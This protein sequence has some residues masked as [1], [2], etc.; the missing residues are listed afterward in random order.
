MSKWNFIL[1]IWI[2]YNEIE[3][4]SSSQENWKSFVPK[5]VKENLETAIELLGFF[6]LDQTVCE[7]TGRILLIDFNGNSTRR[8]LCLCQE[9]ME[10]CS[11]YINIYI[12][13]L[14]FLKSFFCT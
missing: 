10:S 13:V 4:H 3:T 7:P 2:F 11:R 8:G 6:S 12:F 14:L 5:N 1:L 9:V